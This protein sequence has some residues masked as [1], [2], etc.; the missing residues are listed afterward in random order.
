MKLMKYVPIPLM[1]GLMVLASLISGCSKDS[2]TGSGTGST[3]VNMAVS[4][5][6]TGIS[7]LMKT[8]SALGVDSLRIDSAVVVIARIKFETHIDSSSVDTM[9][10]GQSIYADSDLVFKGPFII[11]VRDTIGIDFASQ[12]LPAGTYD[13][14]TLSIHRLLHGE[15]CEDSDNHD[16]RHRHGHLSDSTV[17]GSSITV[18]GAVK[19]NGAWTSFTYSFD[20]D[21]RIKVKGTFVV[22]EAT[23]SVSVALNFNMGTWF[24]N[25]S[26]GTLLD[27]TD[28]SHMTREL[29]QRAIYKSFGLG[30]CGHDRGDGHPD[31]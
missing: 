3:N 18:W 4:F 6:K 23:S 17:T 28:A 12:V 10:G 11:H 13:G 24:I 15:Q 14:I 9:G 2:S 26:D 29:I 25:P 16:G 8:S 7:G 5:S 22:P 1:L 20:G 31:R 21:A 19:K 27:P 30:K